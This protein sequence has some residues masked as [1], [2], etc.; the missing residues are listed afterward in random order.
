MTVSTLSAFNAHDTSLPRSIHGEQ[1]VGKSTVAGQHHVVGQPMSAV[2]ASGYGPTS[3]LALQQVPVPTPAAN[4]VL[5]Q[6]VVASVTAADSMMR[7]GDPAFA[8]LFLGVMKPKNAIPGTGLAGIVVATGAEVTRFAVGDEVFGEAGLNFGAHAQYVCVDEDGVFAKKPDSMGFEE[9]ATLCDGPMTSMNF[10]R[11]MADV[12]PGQRVLINGA[13]GSLGTAAVQLAKHYGADVTGV[14]SASSAPLVLGLGAD[15]VI[16]YHTR[17]FTADTEQYDV[18]YDTVGKSTFRSSRRALRA[19]GSYLSP[20]LS[21]GL[22]FW[23]LWTSVFGQK[24]AMFDATGL[25]P[26]DELRVLLD[27]L[28]SL[29]KDGVLRCEIERVYDLSEVQTAHAHVDSGH[30]QGN[31]VMRI[32]HKK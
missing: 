27:D 9:A 15:R 23:M 28:V 12:Q 18:I 24:K 11:R 6:V 10:L 30:K 4:Q 5:V 17:D 20:V 22:L 26:A 1:P 32:L 14:C 3:V 19:G 31:L 29:H 2:V 25:R 16:D 21:L 8:R 13:A 7:R